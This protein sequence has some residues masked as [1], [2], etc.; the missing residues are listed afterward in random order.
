MIELM[1]ESGIPV[2]VKQVPNILIFT[3]LN[4]SN[5]RVYLPP[6][7]TTDDGFEQ[8]NTF[9]PVY[10][11]AIA[12]YELTKNN[13]AFEIL[14]KHA[15]TFDKRLMSNNKKWQREK[16]I[17]QS[18]PLLTIPKDEDIAFLKFYLYGDSYIDKINTTQ[19]ALLTEHRVFD[20][21]NAIAIT[22]NGLDIHTVNMKNSVDVDITIH[23][24]SIDG[25]QIVNPL[26]ELECCI[27]TG[28]EWSK[29]LSC[30]YSLEQKAITLGL[31][32]LNRVRKAHSEDAMQ[33]EAE[34]KSKQRK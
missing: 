3:E 6:I 32:R 20:T 30:E 31:Y 15:V 28:L 7:Y 2:I 18:N 29:W 22:R 26:D 11:D 19:N 27:E 4:K 17:L 16:H 10:N 13:L 25:L 8:E 12:I 24:I 34:K 14:L 5:L 21:F 23:P 33:I 9:S 1:L